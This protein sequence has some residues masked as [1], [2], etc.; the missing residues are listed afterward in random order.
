MAA[1]VAAHYDF[2]EPRITRNPLSPS[3]G[4]RGVTPDCISFSA[5]PH[6]TKLFSDFLSQSPEIRR[7]FPHS[8]HGSNVGALARV[9]PHGTETHRRVA[10]V[11][12]RQN[13]AWGASD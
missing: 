11:L 6:T 5:I 3:P 13:R 7:F 4:D 12:E 2:A 1:K 8:T 10:D 9:V